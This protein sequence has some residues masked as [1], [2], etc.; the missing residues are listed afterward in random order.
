MDD[1][2]EQR[3]TK[4]P[5]D[6]S[7]WNRGIRGKQ[8]EGSNQLPVLD[9]PQSGRHQHR[10]S[11]VHEERVAR[12]AMLISQMTLR[13]DPSSVVKAICSSSLLEI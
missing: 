6:E 10:D 4:A 8:G 12:A 5:D 1:P 3:M 2:H 11:K 13:H 7:I 9:L